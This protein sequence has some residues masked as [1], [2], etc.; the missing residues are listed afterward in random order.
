MEIIIRC[1]NFFLNNSLGY[2][3]DIDKFKDYATE[4]IEFFFHLPV[5]LKSICYYENF[6]K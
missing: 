1:H 3:L 2:V 6:N 4:T 5:T